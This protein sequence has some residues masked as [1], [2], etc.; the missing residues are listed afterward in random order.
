MKLKN[1]LIVILGVM[2][3]SACAT[4]SNSPPD[5]VGDKA[6]AFTLENA[7]GGETSLA[8]FSNS[9]VLLYFHMA[10]G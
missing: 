2:L 4:Q 6:P 3:L 7:L 5:L 10:V 9:P 1:L 8:N